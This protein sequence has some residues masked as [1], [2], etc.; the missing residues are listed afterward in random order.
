M[1]EATTKTGMAGSP[2][3]LIHF[4]KNCIPIAVEVNLLDLLNMA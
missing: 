1:M 3:D 4:E 2:S